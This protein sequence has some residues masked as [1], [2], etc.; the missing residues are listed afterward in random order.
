V[1]TALSGLHGLV[2]F[3]VSRPW[4]VREVAAEVEERL[5]IRTDSWAPSGFV[6]PDLPEL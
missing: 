1:H 5:V 3:G 2:A 6:E 4:V